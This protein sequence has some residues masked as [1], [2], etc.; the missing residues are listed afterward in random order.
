MAASVVQTDFKQCAASA[1][2]T[3]G[4][5]TTTGNLGLIYILQNT[6]TSPTPTDNAGNSWTGTQVSGSPIV[7]T[8]DGQQWNLFAKP[9]MVG[10]AGHTI[11][12]SGTQGA[13]AWFAFI[14]VTGCP[15]SNVFDT[16]SQIAGTANINGGGFTNQITSLSSSSLIISAVLNGGNTTATMTV[17]GG[18]G[19]TKFLSQNTGVSYGSAAFGSLVQ[20]AAGTTPPSTPTWTASAGSSGA[21]ITVAILNAIVLPQQPIP[22]GAKQTFVTETILQF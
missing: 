11:S 6:G 17:G 21:I 19:M 16:T 10:R 8:N 7:D 1:G 3:P 12:F 18:T 14:E 20:V 22:P 9:N 13:V 2:T 15:T 5:N 4:I